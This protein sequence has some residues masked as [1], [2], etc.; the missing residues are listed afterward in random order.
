MKIGDII[1]ATIYGHAERCKVL[2]IHPAGT[3]DV[4][5]GDGPCFRM[6][7]LAL[8]PASQ[9]NSESTPCSKSS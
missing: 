8:Q 5:R 9:T 7:G 6:S 4:Q 3:I 1:T 2:A